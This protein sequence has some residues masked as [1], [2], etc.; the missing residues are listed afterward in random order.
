M[1]DFFRNN[2]KFLMGLLM[3]LIIPSFVLFGVEGYSSFRQNNEVVAR[4]GQ[5]DITRPELDAAHRQEVDRLM[6]SVPGL[7]RALLES[8]ASRQATLER[9]IDERVLAKAAQDGLFVTTDQRL[10][11]ELTQDPNIAALRKAD[12]TLDVE[13][14]RDLLRAQGQTPEQFEAGVRADLAR[15]QV[16]L[17][18]TQSALVPNSVAQPALRAF[19]EQREVQLARFLPAEFRARVQ[20]TDADLERHYQDNA[21]RYQT[22]EQ[23][24]VEYL[25]LDLEAVMRG[26]QVSESDL[27]SYYTQN[28]AQTAQ[29]EQRRASH[30]LLLS[31]PKASA[32]DKARVRAEAQALL[33][34]LRAAPARFAELAK[35]RSQDP[36]SAAQGGDLDFFGRGAMVKPFEEAVFAL[37]PGQI[38]D[39]VETEFGFHIIQ[40]T[41][42]RRPQ[43]EPFEK[44]RARLEDELKRQQ[45]QRRYAEAAE[46]FSNLVYEQGDSL[47]PAAQKLGLTVRKAQG[48][49]RNGP[50]V[51]GSDPV[52]QQPRLLQ[53]LFASDSLSRKQNSEAL[54]TGPNQLVS[55]RVVAHRPAQQRPLADVLPQ[56]REALLAER[57]QVLARD[58]GKSQLAAW[59]AD[60]STAVLTPAQVVSRAS[61]QGLPAVALAAVMAAPAGP[62]VAAWTG[63]DLGA[64][65]YWV[66]RI[67]RVL[68]R[69]PPTPTQATQ[70]R[71][72]LVQLWAQAET[73]AYLQ[74]LR[75]RYKTEILTPAAT[76]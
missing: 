28:Q 56:V 71:Q 69:T 47:A 4:V 25:V 18:V 10:A 37:Q 32:D 5:A 12:G 72:Q 22:P 70:E 60:A 17:G 62:S 75:A 76:E 36:G 26:V 57:A 43:P 68:E 51:P 20:L 15:R 45:A 59:Q 21:A 23:I 54:E 44:V 3:L 48:V 24:D 6:A 39:V 66:I 42:Q 8:A 33:A 38:S 52:L 58:A 1:F 63:V 46:D 50:T 2:I 13:R 53:A 7:D 9:L 19:F 41:D 65:G 30:I 64:Q 29:Q 34:Q 11:R 55:A 35:A 61:A 31:D 40:L 14:Y 27:R 67:N 16:A 73:R 49:L 74:A